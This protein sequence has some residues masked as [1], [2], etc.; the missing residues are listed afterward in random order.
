MARE[1]NSDR[2]HI[3]LDKLTGHAKQYSKRYYAK[4]FVV[5]QL[6]TQ[7]YVRESRNSRQRL[8]QLAHIQCAVCDLMLVK[9]K[10][11]ELN[12]ILKYDS[13]LRRFYKVKYLCTIIK[14]IL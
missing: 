13:L 12:V 2:V 10:T 14:S 1:L 3:K 9:D 7:M 5:M 8:F 4:A 11:C 6:Y